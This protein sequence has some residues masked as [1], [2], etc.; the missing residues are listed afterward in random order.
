[1]QDDH[2]RRRYAEKQ[3]QRDK[4]VDKKTAHGNYVVNISRDQVNMAG[5]A[6]EIIL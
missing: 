5:R 3:S 2:V 1:M 4:T 6:G